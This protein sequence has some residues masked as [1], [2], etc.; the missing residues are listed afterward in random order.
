M[1]VR[2]VVVYGAC[3]GVVLLGGACSSPK[4]IF[5]EGV[6]GSAGA[7]AGVGVGGTTGSGGMVGNGGK[8]QGVEPSDAGAAGSDENGAA[9]A[10]GDGNVP[11]CPELVAPTNGSLAASSQAPGAMA[12]F[13]CSLGYDLVGDDTLSCQSD[14]QWDKPAPGC[15]IKDCGQLPLPAQGSVSVPATTYGSVATYSCPTGF[16]AV[17]GSTRSCQADGT[18][19]E[20]EPSCVP[21]DCPSLAAPTGGT[22]SAPK[23]TYAAVATYACATGYSISGSASR[24][25]QTDGTWSG[26][27]PTCTLEDCGSLTSPTNGT[28]SVPS[29]GYGATAAYSC[30]S[31]YSLSGAATRTCQSDGTWSDTAPTCASVNCGELTAP[32]NGTVSAAKT[33]YG[34]TATYACSTGYGLSSAATRSCQ[35]NGM[36]SGSAPACVAA[37]CGALSNP[38]NG[39]V[40]TPSTTFGG[41]ATYTCSSGYALSGA[42]TRSC[43]SNA[44]WSGTAPTCAAV[45]CGSLTKPANGSVS[46][47]TTTYGAKATYACST[48]YTLS[49][50]ATRSCQANGTWSGSAPSCTIVNCGALT[51]PS[52]GSV[53][54][55][56][57]TYD[58][59][60]TYSCSSGFIPKGTLTRTCQAS[61]AWSG[62]APTCF[63]QQ[64][65]TLKAGNDTMALWPM[66]EGT[67]QVVHDLV[68]GL[69]G[70]RGPTSSLEGDDP[71]WTTPGRF[72]SSGL[73][74]SWSP[75]TY[76]SVKNGYPTVP[77]G[78]T[79]EAWVKPTDVLYHQIFTMLSVFENTAP[80]TTASM[81]VALLGP[82]G[83]IGLSMYDNYGTSADYQ[84]AA[85]ISLDTWHYIAV[86]FDGVNMKI[87]LDGTQLGSKLSNSVTMSAA[88][89]YYLGG[90]PGGGSSLSGSLG[91]VRLSS[92]THTAG[93]IASDWSAASSCPPQ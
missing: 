25:C 72:S 70:T 78:I 13:A 84:V 80:A 8:S 79:V 59:T 28:V 68:N 51:N 92:S 75:N 42:A 89:G 54:A 33:T 9:G 24:T 19:S 36:W 37:S 14:G 5:G 46:A 11:M 26:T 50:A 3:L 82:P 1:L 41:T 32:A 93:Q 15:T 77:T 12:Q 23:L 48:G 38:T 85:T 10:G 7:G 18:W 39:T 27:P 52:N 40:S 74:F 88:A 43:Q 53:S 16:G 45:D 81:S 65:C 2:S 76:V 31:G 49:S 66:N 55:P 6:S 35:A 4:H 44:T 83:G 57:T 62:A 34:A 56:T 29:T 58:A 67:G 21:A 90:T 64:N 22:V 20:K 47:A 91:P 60:A 63:D 86:T 73:K 69:D 71:T 87:Y 61:G 30:S 17:P